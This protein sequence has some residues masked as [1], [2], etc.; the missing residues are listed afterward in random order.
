MRYGGLS[1]PRIR[2]LAHA[3]KLFRWAHKQKRP[4]DVILILTSYVLKMQA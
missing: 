4:D 3:A 1:I 2:L